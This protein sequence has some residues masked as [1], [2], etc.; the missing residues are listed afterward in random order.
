MTKPRSMGSGTNEPDGH[1][2][3]TDA[4][5]RSKAWLEDDSDQLLAAVDDLRR[6]ELEK[7]EA[8]ISS[9]R[10]HERA[11][12]IEHRSRLIF[13]L[14]HEEELLGQSFDETQDDSIN[15]VARTRGDDGDGD[16]A[17]AR[18]LQEERG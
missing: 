2:G 1:A 7:R 11:T 12:E 6:L 9:K 13:G 17:I 18:E 4:G 16:P 14:A 8:P 5:T 10:F 15:D 3:E